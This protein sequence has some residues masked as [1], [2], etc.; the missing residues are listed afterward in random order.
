MRRYTG[1]HRRRFSLGGEFDFTPNDNHHYYFRANLAG[2]TESVIKNFLTYNFSN[3]TPD[4]SK[5]GFFD[6]TALLR[7]SSTK[8]QETHR[9]TVYVVGG[10]DKFGETLIDYRASYSR[11]TFYEPY[12]F[13]SSWNGPTAA[14]A[15]NNLGNNGDFP[16]IHITD[17]TNPNDPT[18]YKLR[19]LS[20]SQ[21]TDFDQEW[22]Y[23]VNV[24]LPFRVLNDNDRFKIG[25][26]VRLRDKQSLSAG[27]R[28]N[29]GLNPPAPHVFLSD[30]NYSSPAV[31]NFYGYT[32][33]GP[34]INAGPVAAIL[35][36]QS[37][38]LGFNFGA[39]ENIF[40]GYAQ[41]DTRIGKWGFLVGARVEAT[42]AVYTAFEDQAN[43]GAGGIVARPHNYINVF[44]TVQVRYDFTP[45]MLVRAIYS[46]GIGRPGFNQVTGATTS[47]HDITNPVISSGNPNLQPTTGQQFDLDFEYYLPH[48]GVIQAGFFDRE[49]SNYIVDD[50]FKKID[51]TPGSEFNGLLVTYASFSNI[52]NAYAR[53]AEV[54]YHQQYSWLPKPFDGLG[55]D[56]NAT[57]VDSRI[58]EYSAAT[59]GTGQAQ[60]GLLPGT[61]R[62]TWNLAGFYEGHG[63]QARIAAEYVAPMLFGLSGVGGTK[64]FDT[65]EDSRLTVD[66]G[67]SYQFAPHWK[68]YF[69][70]KNLTNTPLRYYNDRS[71]LPIQREYYEQTF[72]FGLRAKY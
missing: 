56:A 6:D 63:I 26:E 51:T 15:Y 4:A 3:P 22:A 68:A 43:G 34:Y 44:P 71:S 47:S 42:D 64:A 37:P 2:Y 48:G 50:Q 49:F 53:G 39:K 23:A 46:T 36:L 28:T 20:N 66:W 14:V 10:Q 52:S 29:D 40:A 55:I 69:N 70:V 65:I 72:E 24:L 8:E 67:S 38:G 13:G 35:N 25:A 17:G 5:P 41:Y 59:S 30:S 32:T 16:I 1:Y 60:F 27:E 11:A 58:Q 9:N 31:T 45:N 12:N 7:E 54:A 57:M 62:L 19:S 33:N 21:E 61:A 18:L